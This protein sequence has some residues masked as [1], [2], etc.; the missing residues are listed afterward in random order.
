MEKIL[1]ADTFITAA[2]WK[3]LPE[4]VRSLMAEGVPFLLVLGIFGVV[5]LRY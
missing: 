3:N 1:M 2:M 5:F 4:Q